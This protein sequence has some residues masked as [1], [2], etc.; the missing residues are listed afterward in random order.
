[1]NNGKKGKFC[2]IVYLLKNVPSYTFHRNHGLI[3]YIDTKAKCCHLKSW[4]GEGLCGRCL[5]VWGSEPHTLTYTLCVY[6]LIIHTGKGRGGRV[7]PKRRG[8]GHHRRVQILKL[9]CKFQHGCMYSRNWLHSTDSPVYK[10][11]PQ[12]LLTGKFFYMTTFWHSALPSM[13]FIF[14]RPEPTDYRRKKS[15]S[16]P[17]TTFLRKVNGSSDNVRNLERGVNSRLLSLL[18][19]KIS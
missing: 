18:E 7:E 13:G 3:N 6:S 2:H 10:H 5:S 9:G 19:S 8:D 1:V 4:Q 14:L 15:H 12:S 16:L 11:L 17:S